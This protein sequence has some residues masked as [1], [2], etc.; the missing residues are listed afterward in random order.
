MLHTNEIAT[1]KVTQKAQNK[2]KMNCLLFSD[3]NADCTE[4]GKRASKYCQKGVLKH[5]MN[6][7][8]RFTDASGCF[9]DAF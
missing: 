8:G 2:Y 7:S 4:F 3:P 6:A 5:F 9:A 1:V